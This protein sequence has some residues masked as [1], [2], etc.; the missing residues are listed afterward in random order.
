MRLLGRA[1]AQ[2]LVL[3]TGALVAV[4]QETP[5]RTWTLE[6]GTSQILEVGAYLSYVVVDPERIDVEDLSPERLLVTALPGRGTAVVHLF[7][8]TGSQTLVFVV[9]PRRSEPFTPAGTSS[10]PS[11]LSSSATTDSF[12]VFDR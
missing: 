4:A 6:S 11:T 9:V 5:V 12:A 7:T 3:A 1:V 10:S 8:E 2:A